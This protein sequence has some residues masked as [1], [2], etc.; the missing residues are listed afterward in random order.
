M[1]NRDR[2]GWEWPA[3]HVQVDRWRIDQFMRAIGETNPVYLDDDAACAAGF[4]AIPAPPTFLFCLSYDVPDQ[5]FALRE[6]GADLKGIL[7]GEQWFRYHEP[8][9]V[10]GRL[11]I[12]SRISDI[13]AKKGG[14][15]EFI[16]RESTVNA[17]NGRCMAE[18]REVL[19]MRHTSGAPTSVAPTPAAA[20]C[21]ASVP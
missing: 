14:A 8:I 15:L 5:T 11:T 21:G 9:C 1:L 4:R 13:Y 10:G 2:I 18:L 6:I 17:E 20:A 3:L 16:V 12:R 19:V 7:H